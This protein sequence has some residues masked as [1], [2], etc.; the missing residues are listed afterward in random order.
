M[1]PE[2]REELSCSPP[3]IGLLSD[4]SEP[5]FERRPRE[6]PKAAVV[7]A[8]LGNYEKIRDKTEEEIASRAPA[9]FA[10]VV[11]RRSRT[12]TRR[13]V[14]QYEGILV[15]N[16]PNVELLQLIEENALNTEK[17]IGNRSTS[18]EC[19]VFDMPEIEPFPTMKYWANTIVSL[20]GEEQSMLSNIPFMG[21]TV[22]YPELGR[23]LA[24]I[25][26]GG[27]HGVASDYGYIN[28][29]I[30]YQIVKTTMDN[31]LF[32][33][34]D[35]LVAVNDK[36]PNKGT[37]DELHRLYPAL[38]ERFDPEPQPDKL[39]RSG[40]KLE[41][42]AKDVMQQFGM[43]KCPRCLLYG[44]PTHKSDEDGWTYVGP[45]PA[46][47][48]DPERAPCS[49]D[50][51]KSARKKARVR[52]P[53]VSDEV[54]T[55]V[56]VLHRIFRDDF[57]RLA[58]C[59]NVAGTTHFSCRQ[60]KKFVEQHS[61][62]EIPE[63]REAHENSGRPSQ[64]AFRKA[65]VQLGWTKLANRK[66]Y[67]ACKHEGRCSEDNCSCIQAMNPC[68]KY[69]KC[70]DGCK[71]R[72]VG[73]ECSGACNTASCSCAKAKWECDPD[74]CLRCCNQDT[75]VT[76]KNMKMQ[77]MKRKAIVVG[78]S[79]VAGWGCY[80]VEDIAAGDLIG[81]Y[82]G[83]YIS[84]EDTERLGLIYDK[85]KCSYIFT[86]N[87]QEAMDSMMKGNVTRFI[88]HSKESA[89]CESRAITLHGDS[90]I[91]I[92]AKTNIKK[93]DELFYDYGYSSAHQVFVSKEP[94]ANGKYKK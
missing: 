7:K 10:E 48:P 6:K 78:P 31:D 35:V 51:H 14:G 24:K 80:A 16:A 1:A 54:K 65:L 13:S 70:P 69:C 74:L 20:R 87:K 28:D 33:L 88:N 53:V 40:Q 55:G 3:H 89:N 5:E 82:T 92:F 50:C 61:N 93:G 44:C 81:Q 90:C 91:G 57:C 18:L 94:A 2:K 77:Q 15:N 59:V 46:S 23:Q 47:E 38:K 84:N 62:G 22:N 72:F 27:V 86:A 17:V 79:S 42:I 19:R 68:T 71:Y 52:V 21:D 83:E 60:M 56:A 11:G 34:H 73:C 45:C 85:L 9:M 43:L 64:M 39:A 32:R 37:T 41:Q 63:E 8:L 75:G 36:F 58:A 67:E 76:C 30:L 26:H 49:N 4:E 12:F 25:F 66:P 29:S